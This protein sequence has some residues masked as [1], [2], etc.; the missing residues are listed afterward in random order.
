MLVLRLR[1]LATVRS[2]QPGGSLIDL[3]G[4]IVHFKV[5]IPL[6]LIAKAQIQPDDLRIPLG[7]GNLHVLHSPLQLLDLV[8]EILPLRGIDP[9]DL[10]RVAIFVLLLILL[11]DLFDNLR[12]ALLLIVGLVVGSSL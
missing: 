7:K 12:D 3:H 6:L 2:G 9:W 11:D 10:S 5:T 8:T 1:L 4:H